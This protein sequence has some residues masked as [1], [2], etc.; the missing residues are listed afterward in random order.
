MK[1]DLYEIGEIPPVGEVPERMLAQVI[2]PE[3][4]GEPEEAFQVEEIPVPE[5]GPGDVLV[6]AMAAGINYNNVWAARGVPIDVTR[7][8]ARFDEPAE[9]HIG[10]SD[11]SGVVYAAGKD[12]DNVEVGDHVVI[13]CGQWDPDDPLVRGGGDPG[14]AESFRI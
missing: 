13:H 4:F 8:H 5:P 2:R 12:V 11:A 10:G 3:R 6:L 9:F 7:V 14:L 1:K